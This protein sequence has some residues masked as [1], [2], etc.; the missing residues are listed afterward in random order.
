MTTAS[1]T[2]PRTPAPASVVD[3]TRATSRH[4]SARR[5]TELDGVRGI[6]AVIVVVWHSLLMTELGSQITEPHELWSLQWWLFDTP[7]RLGSIG[8]QAVSVF[9]VLSGVVLTL[10]VLRRGGLRRGFDP[11]GFYPGRF[12]RLWLP[13]IA[14]FLLAALIVG[15]LPE[16]DVAESP[17]GWFRSFAFTSVDPSFV[18]ESMVPF[19]GPTDLNNPTWSI[20]WELGFSMLLPLFLLLGLAIRESRAAIWGAIIVCG[21]ATSIG[22]LTWVEGAQPDSSMRIWTRIRPREGGV[23]GAP[24]PDVLGCGHGPPRAAWCSGSV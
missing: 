15:V 8:T 12:L 16:G 20:H 24:R 22:A 17:S 6:A 4:P 14:S 10:P 3:T 1:L 9:F 11:W 2:R 18:L 19:T 23:A 13:T 5:L 21:A 7:L